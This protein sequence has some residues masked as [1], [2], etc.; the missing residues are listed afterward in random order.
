MYP[1]LDEYELFYNVVLC[2]P[3]EGNSFEMSVKDF[4]EA[5]PYHKL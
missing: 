3:S 5:Y 2:F 4:K 1:N